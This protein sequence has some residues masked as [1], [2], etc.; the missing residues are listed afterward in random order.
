VLLAVSETA[1]SRTTATIAAQIADHLGVPLLVVTVVEATP[2]YMGPAALGPLPLAFEQEQWDAQ[3][4]TVEKHMTDTLVT[5]PWELITRL[6]SI[7]REVCGL[8]EERGAS[9]IVV[10][11][12]PHRRGDRIVAGVRAAQIL[13]NSPCPVLSVAP[14]AK[15]LP[16]RIVSGIDFGPPSLYAA[17]VALSLAKA[18]AEMTLIN[19]PLP[20]DLPV[21]RDKSGAIT[22]GDVDALLGAARDLLE[23]VRPARATITTETSVG[24]IADTLLERADEVNADLITVG[25]HGPGVFERFALGS[26]AASLL[27]LASVSVLAAPNPPLA[28]TARLT[29]GLLGTVVTDEPSAWGEVLDAFSRRNVGRAV[30]LEVDD[31]STGA[32]LQANHYVLRGIVYDPRD[33]RVECML[34]VEKEGRTHLT[35]MIERVHSIAVHAV[36]GRDRALEI[37]H[38]RGHTMLLLGTE[39]DGGR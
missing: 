37:R 26:V 21:R 15:G 1:R 32:Q 8:A 7:T 35:R 20:F 5:H 23:P 6:G 17:E 12:A 33:R 27:H 30:T 10:G 3:K 11:S 18:N 16:N 14:E 13:R 34:G 38:D 19:V 29:L 9:L 28:E 39:T 22:G 25:T 36:H 4:K 24:I 31:P 2:I